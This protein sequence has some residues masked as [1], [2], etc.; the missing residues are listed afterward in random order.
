MVDAG[1]TD[2]DTTGGGGVFEQAVTSTAASASTGTALRFTRTPRSSQNLPDRVSH[3]PT[4]ASATGTGI[5]VP[6]SAGPGAAPWRYG[7]GRAKDRP[8]SR[9]VPERRNEHARD[10]GGD[11]P[12]GEHQA[13]NPRMPL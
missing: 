3:A 4:T 8:G 7:K 12:G 10:T 5:P 11:R 1:G 9:T 13:S 6:G 2:E